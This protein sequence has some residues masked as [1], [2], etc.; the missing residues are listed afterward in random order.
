[1]RGVP[2]SRRRRLVFAKS[3]CLE[4]ADGGVRQNDVLFRAFPGFGIFRRIRMLDLSMQAVLTLIWEIFLKNAL[5]CLYQVVREE[6]E[7][8]ARD[9][10]GAGNALGCTG[11]ADPF[12][13]DGDA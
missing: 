8:E 4:A 5:S 2:Q 12:A 9:G 10:A 6:S 3:V 7:R 11:A 13:P 1:M